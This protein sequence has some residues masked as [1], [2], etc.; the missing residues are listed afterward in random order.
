M[1]P[2]LFGIAIGTLL[3]ASVVLWQRGNSE[4]SQT[5]ATKTMIDTDTNSVSRTEEK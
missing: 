2:V 5:P 3:T 4:N 1:D